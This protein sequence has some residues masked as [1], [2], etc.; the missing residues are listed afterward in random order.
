MGLFWTEHQIE[1]HEKQCLSDKGNKNKHSLATKEHAMALG[2][3]I[4]LINAMF[5]LFYS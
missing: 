4:N 5:H 2:S 3:V 1:S